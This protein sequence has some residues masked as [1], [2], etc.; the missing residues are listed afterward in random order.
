M[1]RQHGKDDCPEAEGD[2]SGRGGLGQVRRTENYDREVPEVER[3]GDIA[4]VLSH[5]VGQ[6]K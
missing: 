1:E 5:P 6:Q 2:D 3:I 4:D